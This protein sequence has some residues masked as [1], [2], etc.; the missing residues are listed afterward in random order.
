[1][2]RDLF[3]GL[4][5]AFALHGGL[6][7]SGDF[8][9]PSPA[10][11]LVEE[12]IPVIELMAPPP[13]PEPELVEFSEAGAEG[14]GGDLSGLIPP[15]QPD[16]PAPTAS[17]FHQPMQP[18]PPPGIKTGSSLDLIPKL[19]PGT[20][21]GQGTGFANLF[22]LANLDEPPRLRT[23]IE[24]N[25]YSSTNRSGRSGEVAIVFI[26]DVEGRVRNPRIL[27]STHPEFESE[28]LQKISRARF[29]PGRRSGVNV[30]TGN[31]QQTFVIPAT[32]R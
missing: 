26:V 8:F 17:T 30:A 22:D 18:P 3:I 24:S 28:A 21:G 5:V 11:A 15:M 23:P 20:G 19:S 4:F 14:G 1:M 10:P 29:T 16:T 7:L 9:K 27:R 6:A 25:F 31:V 32:R 2:K 13:P 12:E